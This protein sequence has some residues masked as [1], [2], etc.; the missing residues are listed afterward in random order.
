MVCEHLCGINRILAALLVLQLP[1][2]WEVGIVYC[3]YLGVSSY[4]LKK[5]VFFC[6]KIFF[7]FTNSVDPD[8]IRVFAKALV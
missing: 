4:N 2:T 7:T 6:L 1:L 5:N 3:T 8:E